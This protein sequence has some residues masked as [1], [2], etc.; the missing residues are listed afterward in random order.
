MTFEFVNFAGQFQSPLSNSTDP[1][2]YSGTTYNIHFEPIK[3]SNNRRMILRLYGNFMN[4]YMLIDIM[5]ADPNTL[6]NK[7]TNEAKEFYN[8]ILKDCIYVDI[9]KAV[10]TDLAKFKIKDTTPVANTNNFN[11]YFREVNP[12]QFQ[13]IVN[14]ISGSMGG[15]GSQAI[16]PD[17]Q[18]EPSS[19]IGGGTPAGNN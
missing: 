3:N 4:E 16:G 9:S 17:I 2:S 13:E 15:G 8:V 7:Y 18:P 19:P 10:S 11:Y 5:G 12:T 6:K 1:S 14:F